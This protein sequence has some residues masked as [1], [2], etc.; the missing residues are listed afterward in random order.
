[1]N[2]SINRIQG[3]PCIKTSN[4]SIPVIPIAPPF[5]HFSFPQICGSGT[6][7]ANPIDKLAI[8]QNDLLTLIKLISL[9]IYSQLKLN[10]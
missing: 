1:M 4:Q 7:G 6:K 2:D 10:S 5:I 9:F 3:V 8:A